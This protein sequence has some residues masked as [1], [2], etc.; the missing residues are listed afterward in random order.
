[1]TL[2]AA[3][4]TPGGGREPWHYA[5]EASR[6]ARGVE[7]W[8]AMRSLGRSGL[9]EMIERN[10]RQARVFAERLHQAGFAILN[11]VVSNQVLV[12]FGRA[13]FTF[14]SPAKPGKELFLLPF[15]Q[16]GGTSDTEGTD[17]RF[18]GPQ[19]QK[20]MA[21]AIPGARWVAVPEAG[22]VR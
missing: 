15:D 12:S 5:P 19:F 16:H 4:L 20:K 3:Y 22:A 13:G 21:E 11:D 7:L 10:C 1:M 18:M 9:R 17:N 6:R 2:S 14:D 8:A